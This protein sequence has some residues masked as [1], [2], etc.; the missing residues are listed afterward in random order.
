MDLDEKPSDIQRVASPSNRSS[1]DST[2]RNSLIERGDIEKAFSTHE[3]KDRV[4][5]VQSVDPDIIDWDGPDD[6]ENPINWSAK[7]KWTNVFL[8]A[9]I[10][11]LTYVDENSLR[12][13]ELGP[14]AGCLSAHLARPCSP[15][16]YHK[17]WQI[18]T[19]TVRLWHR[20]LYPSTWLATHSDLLS[21]GSSSSPRST[22][23]LVRYLELTRC[24]DSAPMSELYGRTYTPGPTSRGAL[25]HGQKAKG[26]QVFMCT[27]SI[28]SSSWSL[29]LPAACQ[30][31]YQC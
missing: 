24:N 10:T 6:E 5:V 30:Q 12:R 3:D 2:R 11:F 4:Q 26:N 9:A 27:T 14:N 1:H 18:S 17:S 13:W 29:P 28:L 8:L 19:R 23:Q 16:P 31:I 25:R 22:S 7:R 20:S 15:Q 21:C